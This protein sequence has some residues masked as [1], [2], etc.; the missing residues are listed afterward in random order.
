MHD[1]A[2]FMRE[3][4]G[5]E[6]YIQSNRVERGLSKIT[7]LHRLSLSGTS[8]SSPTFAWAAFE[9]KNWVSSR[10]AV[11]LTRRQIWVTKPPVGNADVLLPKF[12]NDTFE[13][14]H[15]LRM[16]WIN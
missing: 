4:S 3:E 16:E 7:L 5:G 9:V 15:M 12:R 13:S 11:V 6:P 1:D 8:Y 2:V 10:R 14:C